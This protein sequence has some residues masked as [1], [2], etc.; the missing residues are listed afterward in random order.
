MIVGD[1][2][3]KIWKKIILLSVIGVLSIILFACLG[4]I[5]SRYKIVSNR[6]H[7]LCEID[8]QALLKACRE[9]SKKVADGEIE[10]RTYKLRRRSRYSEV[11]SQFPQP[12]LDLKPHFVM[13]FPQGSVVLTVH[14]RNVF[15]SESGFVA[16]PEDSEAPWIDSRG[17]EGTQLIPGL[18]YYDEAF[19][20]DPEAEK[21]IKA[22]IE[23]HKDK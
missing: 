7:L 5:V 8:H 4:V 2:N 19:G 6:T 9:L 17:E 20:E 13:F 12:I 11:E 3:M 14:R 15:E 16:Y 1:E 21:K 18:W 23:K 22:I 10:R